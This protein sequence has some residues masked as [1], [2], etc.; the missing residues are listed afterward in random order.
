MDYI[1]RNYDAI[2]TKPLATLRVKIYTHTH[3]LRWL[4]RIQYSD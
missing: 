2:I 4:E 1:A 3:Q